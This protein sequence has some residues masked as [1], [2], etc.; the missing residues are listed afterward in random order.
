MKKKKG[1]RRR[2]KTLPPSSPP[3]P[4]PTVTKTPA[5]PGC[6]TPRTTA[7]NFWTLQLKE[8][9]ITRDD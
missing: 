6:K 4:T 3:Q 5:T 1:R 2:Q 9:D 7:P 8:K